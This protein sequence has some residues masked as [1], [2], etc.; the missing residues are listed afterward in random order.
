MNGHL[1]N[2]QDIIFTESWND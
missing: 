1:L 2:C